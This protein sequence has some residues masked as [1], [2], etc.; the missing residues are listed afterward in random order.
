MRENLS[1]VKKIPSWIFAPIENFPSIPV[2]VV[3]QNLGF[4][5]T[6]IPCDNGDL[7]N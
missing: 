2:L 7:D 3:T 1:K 4:T 5:L 6:F